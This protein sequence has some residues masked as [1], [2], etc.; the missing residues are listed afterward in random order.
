MGVGSAWGPDR[1]VNAAKEAISS[2]LLEEDVEGATTVLVNFTGGED[3][4]LSEVN[5]AAEVIQ[6]AIGPGSTINFGAIIDGTFVDEVRATVIAAGFE[7][8][9]AREATFDPPRVGT[10][11]PSSE[12]RQSRA[13]SSKQ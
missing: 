12:T 1:A 13:S 7:K 8:R 5:E 2:L 10:D 11:L 3:L 6:S 9:G 4:A